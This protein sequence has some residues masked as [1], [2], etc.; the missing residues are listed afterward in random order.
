MLAV[1]LLFL[2]LDLESMP[3][4]PVV[5][6]APAVE[7]APPAEPNVVPEPGLELAYAAFAQPNLQVAS[8]RHVAYTYPDN[9]CSVRFY[10]TVKNAGTATSNSFV[11]GAKGWG[12]PTIS[13]CTGTWR[14][15]N[16]TLGIAPGQSKAVLVYG[17]GYV[18]PRVL[19]GSYL[20]VTEGADTHCAV[21]ESNESDN[22]KTVSIRVG[23]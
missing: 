15:I 8:V 10:V 14:A 19:K 2:A 12:V 11:V 22:K 3:S 7:P 23:Y 1:A 17:P 16:T 5:D 18:G 6:E 9:T 4:L 13:T 21:A 20:S